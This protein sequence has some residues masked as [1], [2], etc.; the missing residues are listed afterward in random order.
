M[1]SGG[2]VIDDAYGFIVVSVG[3]VIIT[4]AAVSGSAAFQD[5]HLVM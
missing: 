3:C 2:G 5:L 4:S 1:V